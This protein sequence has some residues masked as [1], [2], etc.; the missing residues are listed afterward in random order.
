M[1]ER[2]HPINMFIPV[3]EIYCISRYGEVVLKCLSE[4]ARS[5]N[6]FIQL[7]TIKEECL[8]SHAY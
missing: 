7:T 8:Y 2:L 1:Y 6:E 4:P 5:I 3:W